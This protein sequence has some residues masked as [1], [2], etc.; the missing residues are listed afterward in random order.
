MNF[1]RDEFN[2]GRAPIYIALATA[3]EV[4]LGLWLWAPLFPFLGAL[5][6]YPVFFHYTRTGK[7][8]TAFLATTGWA[9]LHFILVAG[10][11]AMNIGDIRQGAV[12]GYIATDRAG[13]TPQAGPVENL[14]KLRRIFAARAGDLGA[15]IALS[16]ISGGA[17]ALAAGTAGLNQLAI[18]AGLA[19]GHGH[20]LDAAI[21][22]FPPWMFFRAS[23]LLMAL[24]G[25]SWLFIMRLE[26]RPMEFGRGLGWVSLGAFFLAFD[27]YLMWNLQEPWARFLAEAIT[28]PIK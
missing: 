23:G 28:G 13:S 14:E 6:V 12:E 4:A 11:V 16:A 3:L 24:I 17:L 20:G 21:L 8:K 15:V 27:T 25:V 2:R 1:L 7:L 9:A 22:S 10:A 18:K 19:I 5:A 26:K